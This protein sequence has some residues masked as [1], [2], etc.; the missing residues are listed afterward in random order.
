MD[1]AGKGTFN[2]ICTGAKWDTVLDNIKS[3][4]Q[5]K[6]KNNT[7][8]PVLHFSF[9]AMRENIMEL[10]AVVRLAA[11]LGIASITAQYMNVSFESLRNESL[12]YHQELANLTM[13]EAEA[14]G[15]KLGVKVNLPPLFGGKHMKQP[16]PWRNCKF[17]NSQMIIYS[18]GRVKTCACGV[19]EQF[20]GDLKKESLM[21]IWYGGK[22]KSLR[23]GFET[24]NPPLICANCPDL[25]QRDVNNI[26]THI[27]IHGTTSVPIKYKSSQFPLVTVMV[28]TLNRPDMLRECLESICNQTYKNIEVVV[29]NDGGPDIKTI[30][31]E[32]KSRINIIY[33]RHGC[34]IGRSA[35]WNSAINS[36]NGKYVSYLD[37]DDIYYPDH[38]QTLVNALEENHGTVA[39]TDTYQATQMIVNG[40]YQIT[41]RKI[42][43]SNDFDR[44]LI[45]VTNY[46]PIINIMHR[47]D[48]IDK[49]GMFDTGMAVLEDW[50]FLNRLADSYEFIHIPEITGEYRWRDD[51]SNATFIDADKFGKNR[52]KV[53]MRYG[54]H[55]EGIKP[56]VSII[57]LCYN[58]IKYTRLCIESIHS[59]TEG[60]YEIVIVDNNSTDGSVEYFEE[61][62]SLYTNIKVILNK[63]NLGYA[64]GNNQGLMAA[65]GEYIVVMNNDVV[66]TDGWLSGL[67]RT[68]ND[69]PDIG[70]SGPRTNN[71]AGSQQIP[72]VICNSI[73]DIEEFACKFKA[74]A[75]T[76][77]TI[78]DRVIGFCMLIKRKV[79][80]K[81]GGFDPRFGL[82]NFED[83]D[84][85][86][87][88]IIAG[89]KVAITDF[90][91]VHHFRN[92]SFNLM[93]S[94]QYKELLDN[95]NKKF[96]RKWGIPE[97]S[98]AKKCYSSHDFKETS[99]EHEN[100]YIPF[101]NNEY[102]KQDILPVSIDGAKRF[103]ILSIPEWSS[104]KNGWMK[105]I[106]AYINTFNKGDDT[107]LLFYLD[108]SIE[109]SE[110]KAG[111]KIESYLKTKGLSTDDVPDIMILALPIPFLKRGTLYKSVD[112]LMTTGD[113]MDHLHTMEAVQCGIMVV[114]P[115][116]TKRLRELYEGVCVN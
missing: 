52:A 33:K 5:M 34:N 65:A 62:Q 6:Q 114:S 64:L 58:Q 48:C 116:D 18:D 19:V 35:A 89:F 86:R 8:F 27:H 23:T 36:A 92:V 108:T 60:P 32:F 42:V 14:L 101:N 96:F 12:Y 71:I 43:Y 44:T 80:E 70:I 55:Y 38:I 49:T 25:S 106:D 99:F 3:I 29:V 73:E 79:I 76:T 40:V 93:G 88:A 66:V 22:Y 105:V 46:I 54:S 47:R 68:V 1:G 13:R 53:W 31:D 28:R 103:S 21:D 16:K 100:H 4:Q 45:K 2:S 113:F 9:T 78:T 30:I 84:F 69:I 11:E 10:P 72:G 57:I 104:D 41:D 67:V 24:D 50:D 39:Y 110:D 17:V 77:V 75:E 81:I 56:L 98:A 85:C 51:N 74:E 111:L 61:L 87:R 7:Q 95:N 37:D 20:M 82:G 109:A 83:D 26:N 112:L 102:L 107:T 94:R 97:E 90:V 63:E 15:N 91:F 115:Y 59:C